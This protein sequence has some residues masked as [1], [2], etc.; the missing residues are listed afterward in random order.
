VKQ[1]EEVRNSDY[2][3][4]VRPPIDKY[5]TLQF[6][7]FDEIKDVGYNHGKTYFDGMLK[8]GSILPFLHAGGN[9]QKKSPR[10]ISSD[11]LSGNYN[12]TDLAQMVCKVRSTVI[13]PNTDDDYSDEDTDYYEGGPNSEPTQE[14]NYSAAR[15]RHDRSGGVGDGPLN[16]RVSPTF[17]ENELDSES[18]YPKS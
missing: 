16:L 5:K 14:H 3:H 6:G 4:Y 10:E 2:C 17:S 1:L 18:E 9:Q 13:A 7:S 15:F 12:F 11:K 8:G